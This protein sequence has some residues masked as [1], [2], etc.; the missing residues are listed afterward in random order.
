MNCFPK[1]PHCMII[2]GQTNC[3]KTVFILDLLETFYDKF[4]ERIVIFCTTLKYN[5]SY[6]ETKFVWT[7]DNVILVDPSNKL[8]ECLEYFYKLCEG[9]Q[10][11]FI[12][13]DCSA[14]QEMVKKRKTLSKLAFSG[15]HAGVSVWL[16][17]QKYNSVLKDFREQ[18]RVIV[19][20]HCKDKNSFESCLE[21][22]DVIKSKEEKEKIK[23]MLN[24]KK[25]CKLILKTDVPTSY[26]CF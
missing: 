23:Q 10:T 12:I 7:D 5:K 20:F 14:E 26:T 15:R 18:A 21:E 8:N 11:L 1:E 6:K 25:F 3:G 24:Q 16:L 2:C 9:T 4:F 22:N 19:L 13:D 17:T